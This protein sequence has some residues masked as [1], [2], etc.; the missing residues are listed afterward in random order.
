MEGPNEGISRNFVEFILFRVM[1]AR[2]TW[3]ATGAA[4][5]TSIV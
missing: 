5:K 2:P 1:K 3:D 4:V